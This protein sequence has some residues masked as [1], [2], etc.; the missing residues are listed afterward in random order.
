MG[1]NKTWF[2][3][4]IQKI[5]QITER[6]D[7]Y[8]C[9]QLENPEPEH[10]LTPNKFILLRTL[11]FKGKCMVADLSREV[12]LTSGATTI[13]LNRLEQEGLIIRNRDHIDRRIVWVD[14]SNEGKQLV[15]SILKNRQKFIKQ[16]LNVLTEQEQ[17]TFISLLN[18]ISVKLL[19]QK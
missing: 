2:D 13:A 10:K 8:L 6:M 1:E 5:E 9:K 3:P 12:N 11:L 18:K 7:Q 14:L 4:Q 16:I 17:E 15:K 19:Q